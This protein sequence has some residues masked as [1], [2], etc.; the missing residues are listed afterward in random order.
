MISCTRSRTQGA[1]SWN[2][3][4]GWQMCQLQQPQI[5]KT[6]VCMYAR[7]YPKYHCPVLCRWYTVIPK[8][9]C[10]TTSTVVRHLS[11]LRFGRQPWNNNNPFL[12]H[13]VD[14]RI[15]KCAACH[16]EFR[17]PLGPVCLHQTR[18]NQASDTWYH[19]E[20]QRLIISAS[21]L[22]A[23]LSPTSSKLMLSDY[24]KKFN[25]LFQKIGVAV[26]LSYCCIG[27]IFGVNSIYQVVEFPFISVQHIFHI[28]IFLLRP[29]FV[30][31]YVKV[32]LR[33]LQ[34]MKELSSYKYVQPVMVMAIT[35]LFQ[36]IK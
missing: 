12:L 26:W 15:K 28:W 5:Q 35:V 16:F 6:R 4:E 19:C 23:I 13:P 11:A 7:F 30:T 14:N 2:C 9:C 24:Q 21:L 3:F 36:E 27:F 8:C 1:M 10:T 18:W 33:L 31:N 17:D 34:L 20:R 29:F 32:P 22:Q 25:F